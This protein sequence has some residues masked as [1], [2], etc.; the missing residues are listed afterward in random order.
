M[1]KEAKA[2]TKTIVQIGILVKNIDEVYPKWEKFFGVPAGPEQITMPY[3][4]TGCTYLGKR[5][6][7]LIKQ[8]HFLFNNLDIELIE[9]I[10]EDHSFWKDYL[11]KDGPGL[12]HIAIEVANTEEVLKQIKEEHGMDVLQKGE[13]ETGRYSYLD[14]RPDL[15]VTIETLESDIG[16]IFEPPVEED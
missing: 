13:W 14:S 8:R 2:L 11:D 6:D 5:C 16:P 15:N 12:N 10:G 7:G 3:E 4:Q 9:P 1:A